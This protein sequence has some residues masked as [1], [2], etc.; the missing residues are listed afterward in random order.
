MRSGGIIASV[1]PGLHHVP[2]NPDDATTEY[3]GR[4]G[5]A[6]ER[7]GEPDQDPN[8][9]A[10]P[11]LRAYRTT[12]PIGNRRG[13]SSAAT[14]VSPEWKEHPVKIVG[15]M[16]ILGLFFYLHSLPDDRSQGS[17]SVVARPALPGR[18]AIPVA[19]SEEALGELV[20]AFREPDWI[21]ALEASGAAFQVPSGARL[22]ILDS[23][24]VRWSLQHPAHTGVALKVRVIDADPLTGKNIGRVGYVLSE[25]LDASGFRDRFAERE[26]ASNDLH[27]L[28]KT[29]PPIKYKIG[30][31][32]DVPK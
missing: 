12:W 3:S 11:D 14:H 15:L 16:L 5:E 13:S 4:K 25:W 30:K 26:P 24:H 18:S 2:P 7:N 27:A 8:L 6:T 31:I 19:V 23:D 17:T 20:N 28:I 22:V 32:E 9:G 1:P 21:A 29:A 10:K